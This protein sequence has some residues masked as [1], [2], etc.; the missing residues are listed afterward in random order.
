MKAHAE[1]TFHDLESVAVWI[2]GIQIGDYNVVCAVGVDISGEK[3]VLEVRKGATENAEVVKPLLED[4]LA[5][6]LH[7]SQRR[8]FVLDGAK[9]LR[10]AVNAVFGDDA[11][12]QRCRNHKL[13]NVVGI[14]QKTRKIRHA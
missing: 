5:R 7:P 9:A 10:C 13:R 4:L 2:D 3:H 8:L 14:C 1:K 11:K 12:V 6:G